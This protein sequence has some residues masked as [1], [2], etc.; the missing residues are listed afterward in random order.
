MLSWVTK[1]VAG[2]ASE[3]TARD[4]REELGAG[5]DLLLLDVRQPEEHA[6]ECIAGSVLIPLGELAA[7]AGEL[8]AGRDI[9]VYC[10]S[11]VRSAMACRALRRAGF[12]R[13]RN[14]AGGISAWSAPSR[15]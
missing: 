13:V 5:A 9:V 12:Q 2:S 15:A 7:R 8:D 3:V 6:R 11:G 14:L 4:L 10:R 1:A